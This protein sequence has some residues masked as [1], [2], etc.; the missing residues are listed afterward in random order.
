MTQVTERSLFVVLSGPSG[1]GKDTLLRGLLARDDRVHGV[2]TAKTRPAALVKR[3]ACT[4][5]F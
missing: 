3:M 5:T 2:V 1:A 4:I